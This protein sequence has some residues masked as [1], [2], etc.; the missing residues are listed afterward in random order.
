M[1]SSASALFLPEL[2]IDS[3][4]NPRDRQEQLRVN[5]SIHASGT[6]YH[7]SMSVL[8]VT[9]CLPTVRRESRLV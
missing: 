1:S 2:K 7:Q 6:Y 9:H 4:I 3:S 5:P 8:A